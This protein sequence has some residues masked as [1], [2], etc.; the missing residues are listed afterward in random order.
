MEE[1]KQAS[2]PIASAG[3]TEQIKPAKRKCILTNALFP[4]CAWLIFAFVYY[5]N[6]NAM[7][8]IKDLASP[9]LLEAFNSYGVYGGILLGFLSLI[10]GYLL[11]GISKLFRLNKFQAVN[12]I[13]LV[14]IYAPWYF[15]A[16]ALAG[17][18][19]YTDIARLVL[20]ILV[21]PIRNASLFMLSV[22]AFWFIAVIIVFVIK[23][24]KPKKNAVQL[25]GLLLAVSLL[26][27]GCLSKL[28]DIACLILPDSDHC[29]Q[30][31]AMQSGEADDCERIK[32]E[33]F[34][35]GGSNPPRDKCY[36][37]IAENTGDIDVCKRIKGGFM[38]Y[39][40]EECYLNVA[41]KFENPAGCK[42]LSGQAKQDC[43]EQLGDKID[44]A[45][46]IAVDNQIDELKKYLQ[47]GKDADLEKQLKG[48]EDKRADLVDVLT[49]TN[50]AEYEKQSDPINKDILGDYAVGELN[51]EAK[52]KLIALNENLKAKGVKMTQDQ[53]DAFKDY[54]KFISDPNNDIEQMDDAKLLK[55]RWNEKVG[56]VMDKFK[57]WK[58][59][60]S[61]GEAKLDEQLRFYER[62]L[63]RQQSINDGLSE[64]GEDVKR[65]I[66]MVNSSIQDK[67][68][69]AVKDKVIET[70]FGE[71]TGKTVGVT[72][73]VVGEALDVVK[74]EAKSKE[75]R[76][77]VRAYNL[78]MQEELGKSGG[79]VNKAHAAVVSAMQTNPY[80]YE[81]S[82]TF[83]KYG[84]VLENKDC[85]GTNPH[86]V[87]K[88][89]FWKAMKKSY[90]YQNNN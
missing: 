83:A 86:C 63:E 38:S 23:K 28:E 46:V 74:G 17:E 21:E 4:V 9:K 65:N 5:L 41:V 39:T 50:K 48:L 15:L 33:R 69:D 22:S 82:N 61:A 47:G 31:S 24:I 64:F 29:Y 62:M 6:F 54:Y 1:T 88:E 3:G 25:A 70:I 26:T 12:P 32:G 52:D 37:N 81:D 19:R 58:S 34:K 13:L 75:F 16:V 84:N 8:R 43:R 7:A 53:I 14:L 35:D 55:D 76:G 67:A 85:D 73:A 18:P 78:G 66:N 27:T 2:E 56:D 80:E 89:V 44:P 68:K 72:T 51:R 57:I 20:D 42:M 87:N 10:L 79:D 11:L 77:L 45:D 71:I 49:K 59:G 36:L 60:P 30:A 90:K 40:P